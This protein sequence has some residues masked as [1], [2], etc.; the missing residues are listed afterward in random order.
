MIHFR[1]ILH[2]L[3]F[4]IIHSPHQFST[5]RNNLLPHNSQ[6]L[7][8]HNSQLSTVIN[9]PQWIF[10]NSKEFIST[11]FLIHLNPKI[12]LSSILLNRFSTIQSHR[13]VIHFSANSISFVIYH[14]FNSKLSTFYTILSIPNYAILDW[15]QSPFSTTLKFICHQFHLSYFKV[16]HFHTILDSSQSSNS[17]VINSPELI[18]HNSKSSRSNPFSTNSILF[19]NSIQSYPFSTRFHWI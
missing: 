17:F 3:H 13:E 5:I 7:I 11:Q 19:V 10:L 9:S 8:F 6:L 16:I 12:R 15:S 1:T 2:S 18:L 4:K 14:Q